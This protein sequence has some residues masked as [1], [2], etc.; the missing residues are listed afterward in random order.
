LGARL[1]ECGAGM[2]A[3]DSNHLSGRDQRINRR[4]F[5]ASSDKARPP[6]KGTDHGLYHVAIA[7]AAPPSCRLLFLSGVPALIAQEIY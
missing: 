5:I 7:Q 1:S 2:A 3:L 6:L 4:L